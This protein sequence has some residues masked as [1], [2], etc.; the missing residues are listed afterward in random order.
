MKFPLH[1]AAIF[2]GQAARWRTRPAA[3]RRTAGFLRWAVL[4]TALAI[5]G[6]RGGEDKAG[7]MTSFSTTESAQAKAELFSLPAD[8][9][10]HIQIVTVAPAPLV[11]TLRLTGS[12]DYNAFK[13]T[14]VI[15]QVGGP[16]SRIVVAPG[17]HVEAH[18]PMLYIA[19]PDYSQLRS[20]Y[21][22]ARDALELADKIYKRDQ[23][24]Y[25][26][27]AIAEA[28]LEQAESSRNQAQADLDS[29][30]DAI[31]I[32]GI[33]NPETLASKPASPEVPLLAP[34]AAQAIAI[35]WGEISLPATPP[36]MLAEV[37]STGFIPVW[38]AVTCCSLPNKAADDVTEPVRNTPN[39]PIAGEKIGN[40][41]PA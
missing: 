5:S 6:C 17:E 33:S 4:G 36:K 14:P 18:Q 9:M 11:R 27:H 20:G 7:Q 32:L 38:V 1:S 8:Q 29:S 26:H 22:K 16:V 3:C 40:N 34:V 25:A 41:L 35:D 12:V 10:S 2:L 19:S 21:I 23:D 30:T 13:T 15:S 39:Q 31:H 37:V 24:L 28:D